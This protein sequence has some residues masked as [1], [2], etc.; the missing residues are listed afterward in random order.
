MTLMFGA[1]EDILLSVWDA[2]GYDG[3]CSNVGSL[4]LE[5]FLVAR[6]I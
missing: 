6:G 4:I 3:D 1:P 2:D 5:L